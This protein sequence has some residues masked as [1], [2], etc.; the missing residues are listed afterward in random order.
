MIIAITGKPASFKTYLA[1]LIAKVPE[2]E[3]IDLSLNFSLA[4]NF[5]GASQ[6]LL[7]DEAQRLKAVPEDCIASHTGIDR[8]L[9][10][11][12]QDKAQLPPDLQSSIQIEIAMTNHITTYHR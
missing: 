3:F 5:T 7:I 11:I 2:S 10:L 6:I 1:R 4:E 12:T 8:D 9:F